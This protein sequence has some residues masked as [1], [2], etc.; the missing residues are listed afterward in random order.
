MNSGDIC[1]LPQLVCNSMIWTWMMLLIFYSPP[2]LAECMGF[3]FMPGA[4]LTDIVFVIAG[5]QDVCGC[6][7]SLLDGWL[8]LCL[9]FLALSLYVVVLCP[10]WMS[11]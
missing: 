1:I 10:C 11:G 3:Y 2:W 8:I 6:V 4:C 5:S 9:S 7:W